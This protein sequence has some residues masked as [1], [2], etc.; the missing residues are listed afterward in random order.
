MYHFD[1][2]SQRWIAYPHTSLTFDNDKE[3]AT[4]DACIPERCHFITWNILFDYHHSSLIFTSQRYQAILH[5]LN[6][7]LPDVICLQ[8]V[9]KDFLTLLLNAAWVRENNYYIIIMQAIL[10]NNQEH[11]YGQLMLTKNFRARAFTICPLDLSDQTPDNNSSKKL[12]VARFNINPKVTIDLVNLHLHS[13][14]SKNASDKRCQVL[15]N[16]F[17]KMNTKNFMLIGDFNFGDYDLKETHIL[18]QA[19]HQVHDL[20]HDIY[21]LE[22]VNDTIRIVL[23]FNRY[24]DAHSH[25]A[26]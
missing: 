17:K 7:L 14:R 9:T 12:I 19:Q 6:S 15:E 16:L 18:Q 3:T 4:I 10:N 11:A 20:W 23:Q 13:D 1:G 25:R 8:E 2:L 21:N 22:E 24:E 5:T 26:N